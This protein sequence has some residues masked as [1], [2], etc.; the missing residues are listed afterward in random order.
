MTVY[1]SLLDL[2]S[3]LQKI[4]CTKIS[5]FYHLLHIFSIFNIFISSE[6]AIAC[7]LL[8]Q[9]NLSILQPRV[10]RF[11]SAK[12]ALR[13]RR[14]QAERG[15]RQLRCYDGETLNTNI[16]SLLRALWQIMTRF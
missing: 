6:L 9:Q 11:H 10:L 13:I 16:Q 12:I 2:E 15:V 14:E 3:W 7:G 1:I 8:S 4:V 5:R